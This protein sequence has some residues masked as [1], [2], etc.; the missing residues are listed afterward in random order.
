MTAARGRSAAI[1]VAVVGTVLV[2]AYAALAAVQVLV[3]NPLAA[4]PGSDLA[5][6]RADVEAA[7]ESLDELTVGIVLGIGVALAVVMLVVVIVERSAGVLAATA[8]YLALLVLGEPAYIFA[9]FGA[10]MA[11]AD[12]YG[13]AGA[14]ASP[15]AMP[16]HVTSLLA[17]LGLVVVGVVAV[18]RR[19]RRTP[20]APTPA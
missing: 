7:G 17:L 6:I 12:T 8:I 9:S 10:G 16:L 14:D 3:L 20:A 18:R 19:L 5:A 4:W 15:W 1:T 13:I 11:L 2:I